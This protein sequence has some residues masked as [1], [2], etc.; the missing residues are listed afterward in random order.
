MQTL[1]MPKM[2]KKI[3]SKITGYKPCE[4]VRKALENSALETTPFYKHS[5]KVGKKVGHK[6]RDSSIICL[7]LKDEPIKSIKS[8]PIIQIETKRMLKRKLML[9][10]LNRNH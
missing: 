7:Y 6:T 9:M 5:A 10:H 4:Q 8:I 3:S 1:Y 2:E